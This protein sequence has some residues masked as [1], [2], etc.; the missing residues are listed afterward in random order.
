MVGSSN[1]WP[2]GVTS[3][4]ALGGI[5]LWER[6]KL[7]AGLESCAKWA[8]ATP[9]FRS[10]PFRFPFVRLTKAEMERSGMTAPLFTNPQKFARSQLLERNF[11]LCT[12]DPSRFQFPVR[13]REQ[14]N[15]SVKWHWSKRIPHTDYGTTSA[16]IMTKLFF[17]VIKVNSKHA[18]N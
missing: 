13:T 2:E 3:S 7:F 12:M 17:F 15:E 10:T 1:P 18:K 6:A 5:A 16:R 9:S 14:I 4:S 8:D 11:I